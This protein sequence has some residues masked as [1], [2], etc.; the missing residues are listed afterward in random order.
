MNSETYVKLAAEAIGLPIPEEYLAGTVLNFERA[1]G[2]AAQ[3][4]EFPL[5][6]DVEPAHV[7]SHEK[8]GHEQR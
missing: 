8:V 4:M 7:F 3:I 6:M 1:A 2:M 5:P